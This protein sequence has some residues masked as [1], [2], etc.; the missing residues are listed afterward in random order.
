MHRWAQG[1]GHVV[2]GALTR[3]SHYPPV[4]PSGNHLHGHLLLGAGAK[5]KRDPV[6]RVPLLLD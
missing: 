6:N 2:R 4:R 3:Y 5:K 1:A